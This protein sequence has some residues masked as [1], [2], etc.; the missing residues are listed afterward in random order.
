M[1]TKKSKPNV[2]K[3]KRRYISPKR[4]AKRWDISTKTLANKRSNGT[5]P[6]YIKIGE[7]KGARVRYLFKSVRAFEKAR[8]VN[9]TFE[10]RAKAKALKAAK[11]KAKSSKK[12]ED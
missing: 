8:T 7:G 10:F 4:L 2:S 11:V 6:A 9:G 3:P 5:G 1:T 12:K